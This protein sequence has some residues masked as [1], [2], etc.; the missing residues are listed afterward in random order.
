MTAQGTFLGYRRPNGTW[1]VRNHLLVLSITGLSAPCARRIG[2]I[3]NKAVVTTVPFSGGLMG[4]DRAY[5]MRALVGLATNP[6]VG[7]VLLISDHPPKLRDVQEQVAIS[8]KPVIALG[9]DDFENDTL[10]LTEMGVREGARLLVEL[11]RQRREPAPI[12]ELV[13]GLECGRSD[14]SSGLVMNPVVGLLVDRL[15]EAGAR[16][17]MGETTEWIGAEHLLAG[18]AANRDVAEAIRIAAAGRERS[19][20]SAGIDLTG[21]NPSPTNIAAGLSTIEEKALGNTAKSG[22]AP[23]SGVVGY[24][25]ATDN[26]G[27]FLMDAP[28]YSPESMTGFTAAGANILI[29]TTGVGNSFVSQLA[30]TIKAS[31]NPQTCQVLTDQIDFNGSSAFVNTETQA[32][33]AERLQLLVEEVASGRLTLGEI[34]D[35]GEEVISRFGA[36]L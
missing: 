20:V 7:G 14:P 22:H 4:M 28:A 18:R 17:I 16:V 36:A 1:G 34:L 8:G 5:H 25:E 35:E 6:N 33:C 19:A 32:A 3:L 24:A 26:H 11:S 29:F 21:N 9:M 27:L 13:V 30:P 12:S 15:V 10:R 23:I 31:A 2:R